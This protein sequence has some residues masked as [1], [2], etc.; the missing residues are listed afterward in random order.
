MQWSP[1]YRMAY[2]VQRTAYGVLGRLRSSTATQHTARCGG[3]G[4]RL[5]FALHRLAVKDVGGRDQWQDGRGRGERR[6]RRPA[7]WRWWLFDSGVGSC[8]PLLRHQCAPGVSGFH[9]DK[10]RKK[11]AA[12]CGQSK[13]FIMRRQMLAGTQR[14]VAETET[15]K[16]PVSPTRLASP[17]RS[18]WPGPSSTP[19]A[20][21]HRRL[22]LSSV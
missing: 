14:A 22:A 20:R 18:H 3:L 6:L 2:S 10:R 5:H 4:T 12:A 11:Q 9:R 21:P 17:S 1:W 15:L 16:P 13:Q 7:R 19:N 8:F